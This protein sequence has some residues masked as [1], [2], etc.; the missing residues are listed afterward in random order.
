MSRARPVLQLDSH[1]CGPACLRYVLNRF[2][3]DVSLSHLRSVGG[4][5]EGGLS[6]LELRS[7]ASD[8]GLRSRVFEAQRLDESL[9]ESTPW[10]AQLRSREDGVAHFVVVIQVD[11]R[12]VKFMDPAMGHV[13][14][15]H[16][17]FID[18]W[19]H[20]MV[21]FESMG[22]T[23]RRRSDFRWIRQQLVEGRR[24]NYLGAS[25]G[26]ALLVSL[27]GIASAYISK[28]VVDA[29]VE[30]PFQGV[31]WVSLIALLSFFLIRY[32][33]S[34]G[35]G[36]MVEW[37]AA[38]L[39]IGSTWKMS[40]RL[41]RLSWNYSS[42][43]RHGDVVNRMKDPAE[44][45][46]FLIVQCGQL[47]ATV[48]AFVVGMSW[49]SI[50]YPAMVPAVVVA[51]LLMLVNF[52]VFRGRLVSLSYRQKLSQ[53]GMDTL[54]M[55]YARCREVLAAHGGANLLLDRFMSRFHEFNRL[56][57]RRVGL[58]TLMGFVAAICP[59]LVMAWSV[60]W[61]WRSGARDPSEMGHLV[62]QLT[63]TGLIF[64]G[65]TSALAML[66][67]M[68][69]MRVSFDRIMDVY[70]S[71][72]DEGFGVEDGGNRLRCPVGV[73]ELRG[74]GYRVGGEGRALSCQLSGFNN[75][76]TDLVALTGVNGAG[77]S[78]LLRTIAGV[79][80]STGGE[81]LFDGRPLCGKA[82]R[83]AN[84]SY[85]PQS[86]QLFTGSIADNILMDER[87]SDEVDLERLAAVLELPRNARTAGQLSKVKV[88]NGGETFSGGQ[89]RRIALARA[90]KRVAPLL[91]LDEPFANIDRASTVEILEYLRSMPH[92]C[93]VIVTHDQMVLDAVDAVIDLDRQ[94]GEG[95]VDI[96]QA[97]ASG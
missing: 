61:L 71:P 54:L 22:V 11:S 73:I 24:R 68:D 4:V 57:V 76:G 25:L 17:A 86:D 32:L 20:V 78:S 36:Y 1:D 62:F 85:L 3:G 66:S 6:L 60:F 97:G 65:I 69:M 89:G 42:M 67:S 8:V 90:I 44:V 26:G 56:H 5:G 28:S 16:E 82:E 64:G 14:L 84:S 7:V 45:E 95:R 96:V 48:L 27:L 72:E 52:K 47:A 51:S 91:L 43:L 80:D 13:S 79:A 93:V 15:P 39:S 83:L 94:V 75:S 81:V 38:K 18:E 37:L 19:T 92:R 58:L 49:V 31:F 50:V 2:G 21:K 29:M 30:S 9:D 53:V 34:S 55:D 40:D 63:A 10:L 70:T 12:R 33:V 88:F 59:L 87:G 23:P 77:K 74:F 35:V 41:P 46:K